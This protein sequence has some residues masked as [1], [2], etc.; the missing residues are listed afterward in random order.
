MLSQERIPC[1]CL[2]YHCALPLPQLQKNSIQIFPVPIIP[3]SPPLHLSSANSNIPEFLL[4]TLKLALN[5]LP[6]LQRIQPTTCL[7]HISSHSAQLQPIHGSALQKS[8][9]AQQHLHEHEQAHESRAASQAHSVAI[10]SDQH[11][12]LQST[13]VHI[14]TP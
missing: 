11:C 10:A 9:L 13:A 8:G 1:S 6:S 2:R 3:V 14:Q 5:T 4:L 12:Q 7:T